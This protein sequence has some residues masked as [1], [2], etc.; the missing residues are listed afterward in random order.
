MVKMKVG[1]SP[2]LD[3]SRV[4]AARRAIGGATQLF[5]DANGAYSAKQSLHLAAAFAEQNVGWFEEPVSSNNL[6]GLRFIREHTPLLSIF[7]GR[8]ATCSIKP[9]VEALRACPGHHPGPHLRP[10]NFPAG[11]CG[12]PENPMMRFDID[13]HRFDRVTDECKE[14]PHRVHSCIP[15]RKP[16]FDPT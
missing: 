14:T 8:M 6:P 16:T 11:Q 5:A 1:R 10:L 13:Q 4:A 9:R 3:P 7:R 12:Q 2:D 15:S